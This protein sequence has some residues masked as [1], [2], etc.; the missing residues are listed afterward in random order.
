MLALVVHELTTN[1][2]KYGALSRNGGQVNVAWRKSGQTLFLKW[3]ERGGPKPNK[4]AGRGFGTKLLQSSV[5]RYN[6]SLEMKFEPSGL[7]VSF[8]L[9]VPADLSGDRDDGAKET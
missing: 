2:L 6:G 3:V 8:S 9:S 5:R 7:H 4:C 1:A